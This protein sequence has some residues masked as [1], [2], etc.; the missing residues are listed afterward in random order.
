MTPMGQKPAVPP[1][2]RWDITPSP[3]A[4]PVGRARSPEPIG[5]PHTTARYTQLGTG[6]PLPGVALGREGV[7]I[8]G[9]FKAGG[10]PVPPG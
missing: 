4:V 9:G 6:C 8:R 3:S 2:G 1:T 7:L 10:R 5:L